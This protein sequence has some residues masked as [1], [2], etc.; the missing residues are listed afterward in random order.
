MSALEKSIFSVAEIFCVSAICLFWVFGINIS[1]HYPPW[2]SFYSDFASGLAVAA[3]TVLFTIKFYFQGKS[4]N[5]PVPASVLY[6]LAIGAI[7]LIQVLLGDVIFYGD[8]LVST[9]YLLCF[10]ICIWLAFDLSS[11]Y[12][13]EAVL[14]FICATLVLGSLGVFFTQ[15]YQILGYDYLTHWIIDAP[16][17]RIHGNVSQPNQASTLLYTALCALI[18]LYT[19]KSVRGSI[20]FL[21]LIVLLV[22]ISVTASRSGWLQVTLLTLGVLY[23]ARSGTLRI[24]TSNIF[25]F[26]ALFI[27][28]FYSWP[29]L[30]ERMSGASARGMEEVFSAGHRLTHWAVLLD[31]SLSKPFFGFGW[32]QVAI[33]QFHSVLNFPSTGERI[34]HSHNILLD[35]IIYNGY[36]LAMGICAIILVWFWRKLRYYNGTPRLILILMLAGVG[37]H[38]LFEFPHHY[39]Y[40][41][42]PL[43][44]IIG[45][46]EHSDRSLRA[47]NF[48][49][50]KHLLTLVAM[51]TIVLLGAVAR[52]YVSVEGAFRNIRA[53]LLNIS[54]SEPPEEPPRLLILD[55]WEAHLRFLKDSQKA[56]PSL[57]NL[58]EIS[59]VA[60][61]FPSS[62]V[63]NR[64]M[65]ALINLGMT[66]E[67]KDMVER[68][69]K[70]H[71]SQNCD[72]SRIIFERELSRLNQ[73]P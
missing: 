43:G 68:V 20:T 58:S 44:A 57:E 63:L 40:I 2:P 35:L 21:V 71:D 49:P 23:L 34:G 42:A 46:L 36:P 50:P 45:V 61:R 8:A 69:C 65:S 28:L 37:V 1:D 47:I 22:G 52:D 24:K 67:A 18:Y 13:S 64:Y 56:T 11:L 48:N 7:P 51:S 15:L 6:V 17:D 39:L 25:S 72:F 29:I 12:G 53:Q 62:L 10:A 3:A 41:L 70:T 59:E 27:V 14:E 4:I 32:N 9:A 66:G 30:I 55:Q 31:A 54:F 19:I 38:S 16:P 5:N 60:Q 26:Y 33:A 73:V